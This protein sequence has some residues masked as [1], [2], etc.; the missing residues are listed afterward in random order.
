M[1]A[2]VCLRKRVTVCPCVTVFVP[3]GLS[4]GARVCEG[5]CGSGV[6]SVCVFCRCVSLGVASVCGCVHVG[7]CPSVH[8]FPIV[9]PCMHPL[10]SLR[11]PSTCARGGARASG[12]A[13][14][15]SALWPPV[16]V[17]LCVVVAACP[18]RHSVSAGA[19]CRS[20]SLGRVPRRPPL[21]RSLAPG[22]RALSKVLKPRAGPRR[23]RSLPPSVPARSPAAPAAPRSTGC[24]PRAPPRSPCSSS[25][26][27]SAGSGSVAVPELRDGTSPEG[28][29][30]ASVAEHGCFNR[31]WKMSARGCCGQ[32]ERAQEVPGGPEGKGRC[33]LRNCHPAPPGVALHSSHGPTWQIQSYY[34]IKASTAGVNKI[35]FN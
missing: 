3:V 26:Q 9:R 34:A 4:V 17:S 20:V 13:V 31:A 7:L 29:I 14:A 2:D 5:V 21:R 22:R 30:G 23:R 33:L 27:L 15:A 11:G 8:A 10:V 6:C 28:A 32:L 25:R 1:C 24:L 18:R 35:D 19:R 16:A 12:C